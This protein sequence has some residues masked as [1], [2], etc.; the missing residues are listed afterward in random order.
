MPHFYDHTDTKYQFIKPFLDK[1]MS[2]FDG[3]GA[4][5]VW[6]L[7]I[8]SLAA[9]KLVTAKTGISPRGCTVSS[10]FALRTCHVWPGS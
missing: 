7:C 2:N 8:L 10:E 6:I 5:K 4:F 3:Y 9:V 1:K